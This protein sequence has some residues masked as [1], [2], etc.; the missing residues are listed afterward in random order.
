MRQLC[1]RAD[2]AGGV[3]ASAALHQPQLVLLHRRPTAS[4]FSLGAVVCQDWMPSPL[5]P[6]G[7]DRPGSGPVRTS[8]HAAACPVGFNG[9]HHPA[10]PP[11]PGA[12]VR[13]LHPTVAAAPVAPL[14]SPPA[15]ESARRAPQAAAADPLASPPA[16]AMTRPFPAPGSHHLLQ[17]G[18]CPLLEQVLGGVE[19]V[20][21]HRS[22]QRRVTA[23]RGL[24]V[25]VGAIAAAA[26][27]RRGACA[28]PASA[29]TGWCW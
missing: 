15:S 8:P 29:A 28:P 25:D 21:R 11:A 17:P 23:N 26:A 6:P 27:R 13:S 7:S 14:E 19:L 22:P 4:R 9:S 2:R 3:R 18:A 5:R 10:S 12:F 16:P 20:E 24:V 1:R